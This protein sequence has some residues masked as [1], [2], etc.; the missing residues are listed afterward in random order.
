MRPEAGPRYLFPAR[1][2]RVDA[3]TLPV[4]ACCMRNHIALCLLFPLPSIA[5]AADTWVIDTQKEWKAATHSVHK[6]AIENGFVEP[7]AEKGKFESIVKSFPEKRKLA[8]IVFEQSPV[9]DNWKQ[10]DDITPPGLGNAYVFL[11]VKP[12][13]YYVFATNKGPAI[14]YPKGLS[15]KERQAFKKEYQKKHP[16]VP[17]KKG[18]HAWHSTDLEEW[19]HLGQVCPSNWMTTA[20]YADGKFYLYY[21][22]PND[23]DPH[24]I[25]DNDLKDGVLGKIHG[26]VFDDPSHGSDC[27]VFRDEDGTFHIIYEDWSPINARQNAW[28]SPLAGRVSS[29][30]GITGFKYGEH[31]PPVDHRTK[32]TGKKGTY[33]HPSMKVSNNGKPLE[34]EIH[35]PKQNAYGDWTVI[36]VGKHYHLFCDF[37]PADHGKSMRMGRFH[38]DDLDKEFTWSGEI[39]AGFHPDP[40]IGFAEGKFYAIMQKQTDFVSPGPWVDGVEARA[41]VDTDGDGTVDQ[42]TKWQAVKESYSQKPGFARIVDVESAKLDAS[43]LPA[44]NGFQFQFRTRRLENGVQ[45]IIDRVELAFE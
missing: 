38:S 28:D 6:H 12:G 3:A 8:A 32:P 22:E 16:T 31:P 37:D 25:V 15:R 2:K 44:G 5:H 36:K 45:P 27:G 40:S 19:K 41:G 39:G 20:E 9:W 13:D 1:A 30:D 10:I 14:P 18:Y 33:T 24:L 29:P 35:E 21:D 4:Q 43:A 23:E 42:W 11:P 7:Q 17:N 34:Y 26:K